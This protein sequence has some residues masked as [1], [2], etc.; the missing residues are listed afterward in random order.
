[1]KLSLAI[2]PVG[3]L[4][5]VRPALTLQANLNVNSFVTT[6]TEGIIQTL[7]AV[8]RLDKA[9]LE[10]LLQVV[11]NKETRVLHLYA[12]SCK[13]WKAVDLDRILGWTRELTPEN[14]DVILDP[15][16]LANVDAALNVYEN[17]IAHAI[18]FKPSRMYGKF[19]TKNWLDVFSYMPPEYLYKWCHRIPPTLLEKD[20]LSSINLA[21]YMNHECLV[22]DYGTKPTLSASLNRQLLRAPAHDMS[23]LLLNMEN[24]YYPKL[25]GLRRQIVHVVCKTKGNSVFARLNAEKLLCPSRVDHDFGE[26]LRIALTGSDLDNDQRILLVRLGLYVL[27][28]QALLN[29]LR[30]NCNLVA[31]EPTQALIRLSLDIVTMDVRLRRELFDIFG[32]SYDEYILGLPEN[33]FSR[34][35]FELVGSPI[36]FQL[37]YLKRW[38]FYPRRYLESNSARPS[39]I[40]LVHISH[41]NADYAYVKDAITSLISNRGKFIIRRYLSPGNSPVVRPRVWLSPVNFENLLNLMLYSLVRFQ[42]PAAVLDRQFCALLQRPR[43]M[44]A[45]FKEDFFYQNTPLV[46]EQVRQQL[47]ARFL[48]G[49]RTLDE[50]TRHYQQ[51]ISLLNPSF[52]YVHMRWRLA[53]I[54]KRSELCLLLTLHDLNSPVSF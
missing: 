24:V 27:G 48:H 14:R 9:G 10:G 36:T 7:I 29:E 46:E 32:I 28:I 43:S 5:L 31:I 33:R 13:Y 8:I 35:K 21:K 38:N 23:R 22:R 26:G 34:R 47:S 20:T 11:T 18:P 52:E 1:M 19:T 2:C 6:M 53:S 54:T 3:L 49:T 25:Q 37:Q 15:N 44:R 16:C 30:G 12:Q 17:L 40:P 50:F 42:K 51:S 39:V 4:G 41:P 45:E